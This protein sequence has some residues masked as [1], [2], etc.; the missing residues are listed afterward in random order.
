MTSNS[1]E[2]SLIKHGILIGVTTGAIAYGS[3]NLSGTFSLR[4]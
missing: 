1:T 2:R 4:N 3:L